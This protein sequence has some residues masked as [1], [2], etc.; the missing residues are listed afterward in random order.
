MPRGHA[1]AQTE[2]HKSRTCL[3]SGYDAVLVLKVCEV[4]CSSS[5]ERRFGGAPVRLGPVRC[6]EIGTK[7]GTKF[8]EP[9]EAHGDVFASVHR[10][11]SSTYSRGV[12]LP[13]RDRLLGD[14]ESL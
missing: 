10:P 9:G 11:T 13:E 5:Q 8:S 14:S 7:F 1:F 3:A 4:T 6:G 12:A 2:R